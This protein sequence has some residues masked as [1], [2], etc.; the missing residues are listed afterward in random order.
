MTPSE[1]GNHIAKA[2]KDCRDSSFHV[3]PYIAKAREFTRTGL[4]YTLEE[5]AKKYPGIFPDPGLPLVLDIGCYMGITVVELGKYNTGI[6]VLGIEI[7]YKRVVKS[8]DKILRAGLENCK[9]AICD[10]RELISILPGDCLLGAFIFF[11]DPWL[12]TRQQKHRLLSLS[13]F[14][15]IHPRLK[16]NGFIWFKTDNKDYFDAV[17]E[18]IEKS[19]FTIDNVLP[20]TIVHREYKTLFEEMFI[21]QNE[22]IYQAIIR[23]NSTK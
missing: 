3:N 11:P 4:L 21:R 22:P 19:D 15:D 5:F 8:C 12:K 2:L 20:R 13:F 6:N 18:N 16:E 14:E 17:T 9:I 23:K 1:P 10:A 7:K